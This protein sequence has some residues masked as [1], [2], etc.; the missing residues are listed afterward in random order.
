MASTTALF[1]GLSGLN[2]NAQALDIIGNNIANANTT[3]FK[4]SRVQ[5]ESMFSRTYSAGTEPNDALGGSNPKQV[6]LG[7]RL[8]ATQR[9]LRNGSISSTGDNRDLAIEGEGYFIVR[10]GDSTYYTRAG[11]FRTDAENQLV[12][13]N[14]DRVQGFQVDANFNVQTGQV[15]D[16]TI[17]VG[18]L[19]IAEATSLVRFGGNLNADGQVATSGSRIGLLGTPT[20][21]FSLIA[22]ATAPATPP[23]ALEASSLLTEIEDPLQPGSGTPLFAAGQSVRVD[24]AEKG[25]KILPG[26]SLAIGAASTV[27]DLMDFL[28]GALGLNTTLGPNPDGR[29]P[30]VALDAN[31]G[32]LTITG[33]T[34]TAND[35]AIENADIRLLNPDG[36]TAALPFVTDKTAEATGESVR[37]TF[38]LY[39]SLGTAL[40]ADLTMVMDGKSNSGTTWRYYAESADDT[41][42]NLQLGTGTIDFDTAGQLA[43]PD[44]VTVTLDRAGTGADSPLR[45]DLVFRGDRDGVTALADETSELAAIFQDGS[46]LGTLTDYAIASDGSIVGTFSNAVTRTLGRVA[47]AD[48]TNPAGLVDAGSGLFTVGAN[49]GPAVVAEPETLGTGRVVG[50]ALELSNVDLGQE[51]INLILTSTGYSASSRVIRTTDELMQQLLVLGR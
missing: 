20:G 38:V 16:I 45:F 11:A 12:T 10:R 22:G 9:D 13:P 27:A 24:G 26:A 1:T 44:P 29:T 25:T 15:A 21:G 8:G 14:G 36:S 3:A 33:N 19:T 18:T 6:G 7:V 2:A 47:L 40:T 51:F 43:T 50:G 31:A 4:S 17:P 34:G 49:S 32:T 35:L 41:D 30:G 37:T 42:G 48:F 5:F 28:A 23:N 39:D 46:P